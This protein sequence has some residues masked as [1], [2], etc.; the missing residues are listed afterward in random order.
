MPSWVVAPLLV[1]RVRSGSL[2][3]TSRGLVAEIRTRQRLPLMIVRRHSS[4]PAAEPE[5][6]AQSRRT[7]ARP[8]VVPTP[9]Q[10]PAFAAS[11]PVDE[12]RVS[13]L[14]RPPQSEVQPYLV[15]ASTPPPEP[16]PLH[17]PA[18]DSP[19][20]SSPPSPTRSDRPLVPLCS[21]AGEF[22]VFPAAMTFCPSADASLVEYVK[23]G[24]NHARPPAIDAKNDSHYHAERE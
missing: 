4:D 17:R 11:P 22:R 19:V 1:P 9:P 8:P 20:L 7:S 10:R 6:S 12:R 13:R 24:E 16:T 3:Y 21:R 15:H 14:D 18:G 23:R 5:Y 2:S